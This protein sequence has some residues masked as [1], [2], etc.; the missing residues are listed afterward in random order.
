M[1]SGFEQ[2]PETS[3]KRDAPA[4]LRKKE[5]KPR[6]ELPSHLTLIKLKCCL[7]QLVYEE[8]LDPC[9]ESVTESNDL[10]PILLAELEEYVIH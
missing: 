2:S 10:A 7:I 9:I 8:A 3:E 6:Q 1:R 4:S 5:K